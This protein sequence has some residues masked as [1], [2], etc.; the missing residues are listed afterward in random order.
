[1]SFT[2]EYVPSSAEWVRNQVA[3]YEAAGDGSRW[4]LVLP[5]GTLA[6][7]TILVAPTVLT[8]P[9]QHPIVA[10][11]PHVGG[12][13]QPVIEA[14]NFEGALAATRHLLGLGHRRIGFIG[15]RSD[16]ES[17]RRR[18]AGYRAAHA[19]AGLPVDE[20]LV[21]EG[22]FT[23]LSAVDSSRYLLTLPEPPTAVFSANDLMALQLMR[24][25]HEL[26]VSIPTDLSVVGFDN[27]PEGA[28]GEPPLTTVDQHVQELGRKAVQV[29]VEAITNPEPHQVD[30]DG[31]WRVMVAAY[32]RFL[33]TLL[34]KKYSA[35]RRLVLSV[36]PIHL[37]SFRKS[38][39]TNPT[40]HW[41][42]RIT[43]DFPYLAAAV[44]FLA[45]EAYGRIGDWQKVKPG[46]FQVAYGR[47]AA[48]RLPVVWAEAGVHTWDIDR[49]QNSP[50]RLAFQADFYRDL[51]R[52]FIG[53]GSDGVF[54]WWYPGGFR[55]GENSDYGV[56]NPDGSDRP[57]TAV[58]RDHAAVFLDAPPPKPADH[59]IEIDR[60]NHP[61][62][63]SGIYTA[64]QDAFWKAIAADHTPGLRTRGTGTTSADCP[65]LA[66]GNT[67]CDGAN[68]PKF[69]DAAF[70][71]FEV[72]DADGSWTE[73]HSGDH[74]RVRAGQPVL[75][76]ATLT[77]LGEARWLSEDKT[78]NGTGTVE[79]V[80]VPGRITTRTP[81]PASV[82]HADSITCEFRL[83]DADAIFGPTEIVVHLSAR[84]RTPFGERI[85]ITLEPIQP[86]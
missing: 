78:D 2:G 29:L 77:N 53:S 66:V 14:Q 84:G 18:E 25:A 19:E 73:I 68:P 69:L 56:I 1:M 85:R 48:P 58:I 36:D 11:D 40:Y 16:L 30:T 61:D 60:D 65:M 52:M 31:P 51:Y 42:G 26:G 71:R 23:E 41:D 63:I 6:D 24:A 64:V 72:R 22:G 37:V 27:I 67:P 28:L 15:G 50:Q 62:G 47:W 35:A 57:V 9:S 80:A 39:A 13:T 17:A 21:A 34:Y 55:Y 8:G 70:D 33:D 86:R 54:F 59:R 79:I 46:W 76:R 45:P 43:Y 82:G 7:G 38:E 10:V 75:A 49:S 83:C 74:V 32:R 44:D 3:E 12:S 81:L 20:E 5:P 4:Q